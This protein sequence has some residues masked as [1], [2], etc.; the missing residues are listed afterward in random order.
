MDCGESSIILLSPWT[1]GS[2]DVFCDCNVLDQVHPARQICD[3]AATANLLILCKHY[4]Q[5]EKEEKR[6]CKTRLGWKSANTVGGKRRRGLRERLVMILSQT[7][8][9]EYEYEY[10]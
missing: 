6:K 1:K 2:I 7:R 5:E 8:L 3:Q 4:M 9:Y 10:E